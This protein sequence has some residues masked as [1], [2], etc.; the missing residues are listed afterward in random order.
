MAAREA[1]FR[2]L[3]PPGSVAHRSPPASMVDAD[4]TR[5]G[6]PVN[7]T[8]PRTPSP[9]AACI[10]A[11]IGVGMSGGFMTT[12]TRPVG[13]LL[14]VALGVGT[15]GS[16]IVGVRRWRSTVPRVW[17]AR[18]GL[19]CSRGFRQRPTSRWTSCSSAYTRAVVV[20]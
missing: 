18:N 19:G 8:E 9:R 16:I 5:R 6:L 13:S 15:I 3:A 20:G 1:F 4:A 17:V 2:R 10:A 11:V 14:Y 7:M 12:S